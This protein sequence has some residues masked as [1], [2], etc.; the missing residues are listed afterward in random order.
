MA[1]VSEEEPR[2]SPTEAFDLLGNETRLAI[3]EELAGHRRTGWRPEGLRFAEL[4]KAVGAEDAGTFSYHLDELRGHYVE[5]RGEEYVLTN[6]G[7]SVADAVLSGIYGAKVAE[8]STET[9]HE[10]PECGQKLRA[11]YEDE[12]VALVCPDH[13]VRLATTLPPGAIQ[14]RS[15]EEVLSIVARDRQRDVEQAANGVCFHCWGDMEATLLLSPPVAHPATG[16][17]VGV[18]GWSGEYPLEVFGCRRC[19]TVFWTG[20]GSS[21]SR[22]PALVAF[23]YDHGVDATESLYLGNGEWD[24]WR[25]EVESRDP[26]RVRVV[27]ELDADSFEA[28]LD[29]SA[30]VVEVER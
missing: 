2:L 23:A 3:I 21:L 12:R 30:S 20:A 28:V 26:A 18:E 17:E 9:D 5:H 27:V 6:A 4:R 14:G 7:L 22:H 11:T 19:E 13:G 25:Y 29:E 15:T 24:E 16:E 8:R 10:C 1:E